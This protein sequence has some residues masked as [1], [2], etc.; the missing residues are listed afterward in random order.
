MST[1][2]NMASTNLL[3]GAGPGSPS[4][5]STLDPRNAE[6]T[7]LEILGLTRRC[8][9]FNTLMTQKMKDSSHP[10]PVD[11]SKSVCFNLTRFSLRT[12]VPD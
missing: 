11:P 2:D 10:Q 9:E 8:E 1:F 6:S 5:V 3:P 7:L 4:T 12:Y